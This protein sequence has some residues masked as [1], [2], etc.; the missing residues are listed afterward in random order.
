MS[1]KTHVFF[2]I[3]I[4]QIVICNEGYAAETLPA[5]KFQLTQVKNQIKSL[6]QNLKLSQQQQEDLQQQL[7]ST[8]ILLSDL[9]KQTR[10]ISQKI[11]HSQQSLIN[12]QRIQKKTSATL[13]AQKTALSRQINAAYLL[14]NVSPL[15]VMLNQ[16]DA[17]SINRHLTYCRYLNQSRS[18]LILAIRQTLATQNETIQTISQQQASLKQLLIEKKQRQVQLQ[19]THDTRE[20][21]IAT[22]AQQAKSK[23]EQIDTLLANQRTLQNTINQLGK[24]K[25]T[26]NSRAPFNQLRGKLQWPAKGSIIASFG[27]PMDV[28]DQHLTGTLIK[29]PAGTPV[30]AVYSGKVIFA[31]W[32][33]GFGLLIIINHG[34]NFMS[35][36]ARNQTLYANQGDT[37]KTGDVIAAAGNSGG[38][39]TPGVYFE[40]RQN[41]T[42]INP[43]NW[44]S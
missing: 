34:N 5:Q 24:Q 36:Y 27:A 21:L 41:G 16:E 20:Q 22:L 42:P 11:S 10:G 6:Q 31:N 12:L 18:K 32:L 33:R 43:A 30:H 19:H 39:G 7:K 13:S 15:K 40:I 25:I 23:Q 1:G 2:I 3:L 14:S 35:L 38:F 44:C 28:G 17:N 26:L 4:M 29:T 8:E 37:I 9:N